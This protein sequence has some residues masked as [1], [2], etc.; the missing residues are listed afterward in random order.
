MTVYNSTENLLQKIVNSGFLFVFVFIGHF[1]F[2]QIPIKNVSH[3]RSPTL[4]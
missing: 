3:K 2:Q 4:I 1:F